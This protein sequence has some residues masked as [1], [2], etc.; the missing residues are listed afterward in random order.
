MEAHKGDGKAAVN[1]AMA[2]YGAMAG[3]IVGGPIGAGVGY[4]IAQG[5]GKIIDFY[6]TSSVRHNIVI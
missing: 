5:P 1:S 6:D 2:G 4:V 3:G